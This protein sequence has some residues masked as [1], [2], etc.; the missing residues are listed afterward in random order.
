MTTDKN[1]REENRDFFFWLGA[2]GVAKPVSDAD[3]EKEQ[4]AVREA[5]RRFREV[6]TEGYNGLCG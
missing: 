2:D 6:D 1:K 5:E 3:F 4:E